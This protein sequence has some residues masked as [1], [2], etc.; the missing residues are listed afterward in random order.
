MGAILRLRGLTHGGLWTSDAWVALSTHVPLSTAWHMWANAPGFDLL[1]RLWLGLNPGAAWW[2]QLPALLLGILSIPAAVALFRYF[3]FPRA[4][5]AVI[6]LIVAVS[7]ICV[8]YSTRYKDYSA[9][10]V[11]A[12][13]LLA[14]AEA[15]RRRSSARTLGATAAVSL[16]SFVFSASS[17]TLVVGVWAGLG[18][19]ALMNRSGFR[20][21]VAWS[22]ATLGGSV[23]IAALFYRH[24]SPYLNRSWHDHFLSLRSPLAL[25]ES[26]CSIATQTYGGI[27]G[28]PNW[29]PLEQFLLFSILSAL[30][31]LG[32]SRWRAMLIPSVVL[33]A[34]AAGCALGKIPLGTGRTDEVLYPALL[35]LA[36]SGAVRV[37]EVITSLMK[38]TGWRRAPFRVF[39]A[40]AV[41]ALVLSGIG[42]NTH[43]RSLDVRTIAQD[44]NHQMHA[45]DH[46]V[47]GSFV[48]YAWALYEEPHPDIEFG[49]AWMTGFTVA[50]TQS[51]VFLEPSFDVEGDQNLAGWTQ[52]LG[53]YQ[54]LWFVEVALVPPDPLLVR[55]EAAGWHESRAVN[56]AGCEA[57]LLVR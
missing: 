31:V 3:K 47:V 28:G 5:G 18:L 50:S 16:C 13:V 33:A 46:I 11:L 34:A 51:H 8:M 12:C 32:V 44:I 15:T 48:R 53:G 25:L 4:I 2:G 42:L 17:L 57:I 41:I 24:L 35:L 27:I 52:Q 14:C 36:A 40:I 43:Y 56:A 6:A 20:R 30:V 37:A 10:F 38:R 7:P 22:S 26:V 21:Y 29:T 19:H 49:S 55:L 9:D 1:D 54:R 39:G 45:G 23:L